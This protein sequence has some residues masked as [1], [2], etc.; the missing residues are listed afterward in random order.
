MNSPLNASQPAT[1]EVEKP[2]AYT[3]FSQ[4]RIAAWRPLVKPALAVGILLG[5]GSVLII[6]GALFQVY[7]A[8]LAKIDVRYDDICEGQKTCKVEFEVKDRALKGNIF[9]HYRLTNYYQNHKRYV[10]SRSD[11][12]LAGQYVKYEDMEECGDFRSTNGS[13][14]P[15][16]LILPSGAVAVSFFNDTFKWEGTSTANFT[17]AGISWRSDRDKLFKRLSPDYET[18][19]KWLEESPMSD[20]FPG[21]Q[22]NEHFIVWMRSAALSDFMKLY[23]RCIGCEIP[24]GKYSIDIN[25]NYN[26]SIFKGE[27]HIVL[28][29]AG[30][31]GGKNTFIPISYMTVGVILFIFGIVVL[32]SH[33]FFPRTL[34]DTSFLRKL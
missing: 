32:V 16:T 29:E 8:P 34:G 10:A 15:E 24:I 28:S 6:I 19:H 31:W 11:S 1:E 7:V 26:T 13:S 9:L 5:L 2:P 33:I 12:Q 30:T 18:G 20:N 17:T 3:V 25:N 4:Q 14:V 27:K 22:R 21:G 23:A